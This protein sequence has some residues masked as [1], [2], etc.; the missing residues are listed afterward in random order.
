MSSKFA[1]IIANTEYTDP[2]LAQLTAPGR[3]AKDFGRVLDS[4]DIGAFDDVIMLINENATKVNETIDYFFALKKPDDLLVLYFS[5]HGVRDEYGALYLAVK[6][7]SRARLRSTAIKSDFIREAM[8]QSRSRRQV[9]ILDCCNSGAFAQGTKA[10]T[11]GSVGTA[12]AFEGTGYGRVVLTASDSTQFAWEGD[13]VIGE[14]DN[15]LFTHFLVKGLEGEADNDGDGRITIDELYD[16]AYQ[17][18]VNITPK[19]TPGKWSYK[20]QGEIVL[21]HNIRIEDTKPI[22]L[23]VYLVNALDNPDS[24]VR[25]GAVQSLARLLTGK[26]MGLARSAREALERIVSEDDSRRVSLAAT[27]V[28][29]PIRQAE[30]KAEEARKAKEEAER[31][32]IQQAEEERI[33]EEKA[34]SE[35]KAREEAQLIALQQADEERIA[36]EKTQQERL[37]REKAEA[38]QRRAHKA[39][40]EGVAREKTERDRLAREKAESQ[41]LATKKAKEERLAQ[42]KAEQKRLEQEKAKAL[43]LASEALAKPQ[44]PFSPRTLYSIIVVGVIVAFALI[45]MYARQ[46][47]NAEPEST[48]TVP[49]ATVPVTEEPI[50][51]TAPTQTIPLVTVTT[52]APE[53]PSE[54]PSPIIASSTAG[55]QTYVHIASSKAYLYI[56]PDTSFNLA[57]QKAYPR[58]EQMTVLARNLSGLWFLCE[59]SDGNRGW[60][61][62]AWIDLDTDPLVIP[63]ASYIPTLAPTQASHPGGGGGGSTNPTSC[64]VFCNPD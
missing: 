32:A 63:T 18:I 6:N 43:P 41:R 58:G 56:G 17:H 9:L 51:I 54:T 48:P 7:T 23:P 42:E 40:A 33:A 10:E 26:N 20:Q 24:D 37:E 21:R 25:L 8:D 27:Q 1:L 50:P 46:Q 34:E 11:G 47:R 5:G 61:Y 15:S 36:R 29:E 64:G 57:V 52:A 31:I 62:I 22:P 35:R 39:E 14:T 45:G 12:S 19:Q 2:G 30:Q 60:L 38:E 44:S 55:I 49:A 53:S 13:K 4:P 59:A 16:Y 3:D 28:L